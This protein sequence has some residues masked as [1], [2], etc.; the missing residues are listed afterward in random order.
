MPFNLTHRVLGIFGQR[1][2]RWDNGLHRFPRKRGVLVLVHMLEVGM[3]MRD[4]PIKAHRNSELNRVRERFICITVKKKQNKTKQNKKYFL[5]FLR[6][7]KTGIFL[8]GF[9]KKQRTRT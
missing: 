1:V 6:K 7:P 5:F 9:R 4:R 2:R 3:E 8:F